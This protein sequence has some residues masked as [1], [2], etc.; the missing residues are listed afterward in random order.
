MLLRDMITDRIS[1][2]NMYVFI[3]GH[4]PKLSVAEILAVLPKAKIIDQTSSYL[5]IDAEEFDCAELLDRL[6]GTI[7]I[8]K[9]I[10]SQISRKVTVEKL[11]ALKKESKLN[12]GIS[13]YDCKPDNLGMEIKNELKTAGIS[14]RLV[15]SKDK[16]L[17]S[18]VVTKNQCAE[19]L[20]LGKKWLGET[21][22]V[23]DFEDYGRRDFGRPSRDLVSG[24]MP[25]KLAKIMINLAQLPAGETIL[26]P[27]CGSGTVLQEGLLL[28][29]KVA[30]S[31]ISEKAI[32]DTKENLEWLAKN[33]ELRTGNSQPSISSSKF[34]V[35]SS[36]LFKCDVRQLSKLIK[37]ADA[38]VT[39]PYL[40]PPLRGS[41]NGK[42]ILEIIK[43]LSDLYDEAFSEFRKILNPGAKI[44]IVFPAFR[45]GKEIL[46]L[47]VLPQI[48]KLGFTQVNKD[49]L[50][51]SREGQKVWRQVFVFQR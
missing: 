45:V 49:K 17:S 51:Y 41:E 50:V 48:K 40:G 19:F 18:V 11:K 25:P 29:Y 43:E 3:L 42:Q 8:G 20:V 10:G 38:I 5:I 23:Q 32:R 9:I 36:Q 33:L 27:F 44:V 21:C 16:A 34:K 39:E 15:T 26:D 35:Q 13:Y 37:Q 24:S 12:F 6:G 46:E 30:G 47:P 22:A 7:K 14:C 4:N 31:D 2:I 1:T 28:G